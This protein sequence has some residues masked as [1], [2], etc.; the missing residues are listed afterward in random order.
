M[1][2]GIVLRKKARSRLDFARD[3]AVAYI[4]VEACSY[5]IPGAP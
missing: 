5:R 1:D 2:L 3:P 4:D